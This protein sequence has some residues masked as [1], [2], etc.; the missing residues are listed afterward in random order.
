[1]IK[2]FFVV[3]ALFS[4]SGLALPAENWT[5]FRGST[6]QGI[7]PATQL[8][9]EWSANKN[10][11]WKQAIPGE[12]W[13]S[14]VV[15]AG[16]VFLTTS[17][18]R[19][20]G[21]LSLRTLS[22]D[23]QTG[24]VLWN[25]EV[26][27]KD[28]AKAHKKNSQASP[29]PLIEGNRLYVHFGHLGTACLD[30]SGKVVWRNDTL[31]YPPVHGNGG[32]PI[33]VDDLLVFSCDGKDE[34]FI[35]ALNKADGKLRWKTVRVT[36]AKKKFSFNTPLLIEVKGQKQIVSCASGAV[37]AYEPKTGKEIWRARYGEGFVSS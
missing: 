3:A 29:T 30:L 12:G 26:F 7:S 23:A 35:V 1:M 14:P 16:R 28:V 19:D 6:G 17:V 33:G 21:K 37:I 32:S 5:E 4:S 34:P 36:D 9:T 11:A 2:A 31:G 8:P 13:S 25:T 24:K 22:L 20:G 18:S 27:S 10:I 15:V